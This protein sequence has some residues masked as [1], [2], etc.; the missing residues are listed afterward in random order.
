MNLWEVGMLKYV[1]NWQPS[2]TPELIQVQ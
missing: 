1:G 2:L